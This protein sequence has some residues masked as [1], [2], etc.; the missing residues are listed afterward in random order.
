MVG[1][2]IGSRSTCSDVTTRHASCREIH[3]MASRPSVEHVIVRVLVN[4]EEHVDCSCLDI[5][6]VTVQIMRGDE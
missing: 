3:R 4:R 5:A 1:I 2:S 6:D